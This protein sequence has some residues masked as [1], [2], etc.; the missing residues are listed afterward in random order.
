M[1]QVL[2]ADLGNSTLY[3]GVFAAD[4]LKTRFRVPMEQAIA[5]GGIGRHVAPR[6]RGSFAAVVMCSVVPAHT[7]KVVQALAA[8]VG[9]RPIVLTH[10]NAGLK[11]GYR[12]PAQ[13]GADRLACALGA[14]ARFPNRDV[15]IV[16]CGT[17]T[18]LTAVARDGTLLGGAIL[19]GLGLWPSMLASHTA[20]LPAIELKGPRPNALGRSTRAGIRAGILLGHAGAIREL[21]R[22]LA[23]EAFGTRSRP[24]VIGTGGQAGRFA[25]EKLFTAWEPDLILAGLHSVASRTDRH[26]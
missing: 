11:F 3:L 21:T 17:A 5:P 23:A 13:L 20:R 24:V 4:V 1:T 12:R 25:E 7:R 15:I 26:A 19:P 14:G 2:V 10:R 18:T 9:L 16:D 6:L 8:T 22:G